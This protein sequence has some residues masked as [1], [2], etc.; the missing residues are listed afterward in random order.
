MFARL[1]VFMPSLLSPSHLPTYLPVRPFAS[2]PNHLHTY[3]TST[4]PPSYLLICRLSVLSFARL[5]NNTFP[6]QVTNDYISVRPSALPTAYAAT[7]TSV[8]LSSS[9]NILFRL[10][11]PRQIIVQILALFFPQDSWHFVPSPL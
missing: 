2:P 5:S 4:H 8:S 11:S 9:Q 3:L 6:R 7:R 10:Q 1:F